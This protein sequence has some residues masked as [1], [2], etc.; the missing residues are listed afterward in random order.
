MCFSATAS[1]TSATILIP[2]GAYCLRAASRKKPNEIPTA[3]VPFFFGIQ[4]LSEGFVWH[5]I[6]HNDNYLIK[7]GS[8]VFLFFALS[9]WPFWFFFTSS[10]NDPRSKARMIFA[11]CAFLSIGWFWFMYRP[12]I[13]NAEVDLQVKVINHSLHYS[14]APIDNLSTFVKNLLRMLYFLCVAVPLILGPGSLGRGYGIV[15]AAMTIFAAV[16]FNYAFI[17]VWCFFAAIITIYLARYFYKLEPASK[18]SD[19][20]SVGCGDESLTRHSSQVHPC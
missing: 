10:I 4:Q 16:V 15:F 20:C 11:V 6:E 1:F 8:L 19:L 9:F 18:T 2:V 13:E 17:S 5:G 12:L 3:L 14:F 7:N